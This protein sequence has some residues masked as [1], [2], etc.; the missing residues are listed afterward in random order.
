MSTIS[1]TLVEIPK[2]QDILDEM[3]VPG[4]LDDEFLKQ[5]FNLIGI[6]Y[7]DLLSHAC[8]NSLSTE[9]K[10]GS[11]SSAFVK[12]NQISEQEGTYEEMIKIGAIGNLFVIWAKFEQ[13]V[14]RHVP[15]TGKVA[16]DCQKAHRAFMEKQK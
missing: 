4:T 11:L 8:M 1:D 10:N 15:I 2:I 5:L 7:F 12:Y 14:Y 6:Y 9:I 3:M 16:G 13:F